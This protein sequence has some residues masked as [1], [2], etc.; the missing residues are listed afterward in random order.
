MIKVF[1]QLLA[2]YLL[3]KAPLVGVFAKQMVTIFGDIGDR[4]PVSSS[5][6]LLSIKHKLDP[7]LPCRI[8]RARSSLCDTLLHL[9]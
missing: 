1:L 8:S 3:G 7:P 9:L 6:Q 2:Y 4:L 5:Q